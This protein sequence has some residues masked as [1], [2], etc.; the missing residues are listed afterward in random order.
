MSAAELESSIK[1]MELSRIDLM[2]EEELLRPSM[3]ITGADDGSF[4]G[5]PRS[6]NVSQ[7]VAQGTQDALSTFGAGG[8]FA[9]LRGGT[10]HSL[11]VQQT[12]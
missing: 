6:A 2:T 3:A 10:L 8:R 4:G 7:K 11:L 5:G 9:M 12:R 1:D